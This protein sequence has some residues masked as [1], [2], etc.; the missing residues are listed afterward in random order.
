MKIE[1]QSIFIGIAFFLIV[2][3]TKMSTL[4]LG[5]Y[6]DEIEYIIPSSINT[7]H[8][9]FNPFIGEQIVHPQL[10]YIIIALGFSIF[11]ISAATSHVIIALFAFLAVFFTYLLGKEMYNKHIGIIAAILMFF[12]PLFFSQSGLAYHE[13]PLTALSIM[14]MYFFYKKNYLWYLLSGILL[15]LMK[16]TGVLIILSIAVYF[17]IKNN[18][19]KRPAKET[20]NHLSMIF[21]PAIILVLWMAINYFLYGWFFSPIL[22]QANEFQT[23]F[24][25]TSALKLLKIIKMVFIDDYHF[26][27][28]GLA[29]LSLISFRKISRK[30][31]IV[32]TV[33]AGFLA[34]AIF[35]MLGEKE[36]IL[37]FINSIHRFDNLQ[38]YIN[39]LKMY[40]FIIAPLVLILLLTWKQIIPW[41][42]EEKNYYLLIPIIL[43]L[44]FFS[45]SIF[46]KRYFLHLY[47]L[48]F[49]ISI[50]SIYSL[51]KNKTYILSAIMLILFITSYHKVEYYHGELDTNLEYV[52]FVRVHMRAA[53]YLEENHPNDKILA[54]YKYFT[55]FTLR[56]PYLGYVD[57]ELKVITA[58]DFSTLNPGDFDIFIKDFSISSQDEEY[59]KE[60]FELSLIKEFNRGGKIVRIYRRGTER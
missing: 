36:L 49:L 27:L 41:I 21:I 4:S 38:A 12:T 43:N 54:P 42:K 16:E 10:L 45:T 15:V 55:K 53:S 24:I 19:L 28:T 3:A 48:I 39:S 51:L 40:R 52:D 59:L 8:N 30:Y 6:W 33:L 17:C 1:K 34:I 47:P 14:A 11:G 37:N 46:T 29:F 31:V 26:I 18:I 13:M 7:M 57:T 50:S 20:I 58:R 23:P 60:R 32:K 5:Y 35:I 2:I 56:E 9:N 22:T 44:L 25:L